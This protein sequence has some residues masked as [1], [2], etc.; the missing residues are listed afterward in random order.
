MNHAK[1]GNIKTALKLIKNRFDKN[2]NTKIS[3]YFLNKVIVSYSILPDN[4]PKA[5][6]AR[7]MGSS[8]VTL[9]IKFTTG[10]KKAKFILRKTSNGS[11]VI[12]NIMM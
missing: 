3:R 7:Q 8:V 6:I 4:D 9:E 2:I 10:T 12:S 1:S 11:W 5:K